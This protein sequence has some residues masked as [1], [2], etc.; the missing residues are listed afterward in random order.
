MML[1]SKCPLEAMDFKGDT[2]QSLGSFH[3]FISYFS[4]EFYPPGNL[5]FSEPPPKKCELNK[6][7]VK[8]SKPGEKYFM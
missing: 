1:G 4:I 7:V 8:M 6:R 5:S 2:I 3:N